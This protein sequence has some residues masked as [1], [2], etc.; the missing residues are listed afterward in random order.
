MKK[1]GGI[2]KTGIS[3]EIQLMLRF[4]VVKCLLLSINQLSF[5]N[6]VSDAQNFFLT[7][8]VIEK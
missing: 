4:L 1:Q 2:T 5:G 3:I 8:L 7:I 6:Q